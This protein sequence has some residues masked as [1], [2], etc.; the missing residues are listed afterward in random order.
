MNVKLDIV[1]N[2]Q[3]P[4]WYVNSHVFK[5][6]IGSNNVPV[7]SRVESDQSD[8]SEGEICVLQVQSNDKG[9]YISS[10]TSGSSELQA[11][12]SSSGTR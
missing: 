5:K 7:Q 11:Q 10:V 9:E 12:P 6:E 2:K 4:F 1:P 3:E 8:L